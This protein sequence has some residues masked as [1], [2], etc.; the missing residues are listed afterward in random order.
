MVLDMF[1]Y[2]GS[3]A[4]FIF[5]SVGKCFFHACII[6]SRT[7]FDQTKMVE[8]G[9]QCLSGSNKKKFVT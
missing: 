2:E 6:K 1:R 5:S 7:P 4:S 8:A 3:E 9:G